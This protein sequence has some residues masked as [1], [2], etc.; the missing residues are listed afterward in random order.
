MLPQRAAAGGKRAV[1]VARQYP[2]YSRPTISISASPAVESFDE[3]ADSFDL[4]DL[5]LDSLRFGTGG[6]VLSLAGGSRSGAGAGK[7]SSSSSTS[8]T[9]V[10][11][12][13]KARVA[14]LTESKGAWTLPLLDVSVV[15]GC[16]SF[17]GFN[18]ATEIDDFVLAEYRDDVVDDEGFLLSEEDARPLFALLLSLHD[19][20]FQPF[21]EPSKPP[22]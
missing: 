1:N 4:V 6:S 3:I 12:D 22:S 13:C 14:S 20:G 11:K 16:E 18:D 7:I 9:V 10:V 2:W 17:R 19:D 5:A 8:G 21:E 15:G